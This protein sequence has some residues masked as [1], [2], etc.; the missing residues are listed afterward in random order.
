MERQI[1]FNLFLLI[2]NVTTILKIRKYAI[3]NI[4][5]DVIVPRDFRRNLTY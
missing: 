3:V 2:L 5:S 1:K 4:K